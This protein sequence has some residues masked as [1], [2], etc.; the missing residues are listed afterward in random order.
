MENSITPSDP[1][2][3]SEELHAGEELRSD[4]REKPRPYRPRKKTRRERIVSRLRELG[5]GLI[6]GAADDDPSGIA[7]YS[8]AGAAFGYGLLWTALVSLPLMSAIQLMCARIGIVARSGLAAVLREHYPRWTLW[9]AC[10]LLVIGN[11]I[12]I[13]ADLAGMSAGASL[14][15]GIS[16]VWFVP[17]FTVMILMLL[18]FASYE[19]MTRVLK[20]LTLALFSYVFAAMLSGASWV[21]VMRGTVIPHISLSREY[22]L[23]FVAIM[24][25]TISPYLFFWQAAQNAEQDA[26]LMRRIVGRPRRAVQ[27]ELRA[28]AR[29]VNAGMLFSNLI[30]YFI[31]LTAGATLNRA[32]ITN[33]QTAEQAATALRPLAGD[34][35][36]LL[37]TIGLVGTGMLGI[38]VLAGSAA[39]AIAEAA[40]W[41]AG[42]DEKIHNARQ[43]YAVMAVAMI[44]GMLL[45]FFHVNAIKLLIGSAVINGL[46]APPLIAIVLVVCNNSKVM[47][48][49]KNKRTLNALGGLG[50]AMMT[51]A[52]IALVVS[53]FH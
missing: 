49:H 22:L 45:N 18:V 10:G 29:D 42:M 39:Y 48:A 6:T 20:W 27:R 7:T 31:I 11:T 21:D 53:W 30:M 41:R 28:A 13:A 17:A 47:G 9:L 37:F 36:A 4:R 40:A 44:G 33:V 16:S 23:T 32:G 2:T 12:N 8:Q 5:P 46:L 43:F 25:T 19:N 51:F 26:H 34:A 50:V 1:D 35:A 14:L 15:T 38:P 24:G 3:A 52:A